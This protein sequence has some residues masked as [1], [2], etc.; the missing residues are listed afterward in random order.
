MADQEC[1]LFLLE[2]AGV[3]TLP[4]SAFGPG[5][6]GH[7]RISFARRRAGDIDDALALMRAA[8]AKL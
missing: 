1:S 5:G 2:K 7:L 4:G 6:E 3:S 8:L